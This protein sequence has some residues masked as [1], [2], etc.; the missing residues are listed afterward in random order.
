MSLSNFIT[1]RQVRDADGN[2]MGMCGNKH[3][4]ITTDTTT[5]IF[6]GKGILLR[7]IIFK[8]SSGGSFD[9]T[10]IDG[11]TI[12]SSATTEYAGT[13]EITEYL[14]NGCKIVTSG[15]AANNGV[16]TVVYF[17]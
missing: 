10:D 9:I 17:A 5:T 4:N 8:E 13:F 7:V 2:V 11:N 15:I 16:I 3:V 14:T 6:T 1:A 12:Y